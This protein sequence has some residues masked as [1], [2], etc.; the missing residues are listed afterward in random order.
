MNCKKTKLYSYIV[1]TYIF[2][3]RNVIFV[4]EVLFFIDVIWVFDACL[5]VLNI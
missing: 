4:L 1:Y 5:F 2:M 3:N